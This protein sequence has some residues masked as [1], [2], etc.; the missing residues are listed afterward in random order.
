MKSTIILDLNLLQS[1][2]NNYL[3]IIKDKLSKIVTVA[4]TLSDNPYALLSCFI[5][6]N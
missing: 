5:L 2:N 6:F 3:S 1:L 4:A